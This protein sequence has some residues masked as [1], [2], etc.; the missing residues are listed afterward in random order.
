MELLKVGR[1]VLATAALLG[2]AA[3]LSAQTV[4]YSTAGT[5]SGG[6]GGTTCSST[7]CS[8]DGFTLS[9][10]NAPSTN[11]MAPK[12]IDLGQFMT[13]FSPTGG[14]GPLTAFTGVSFTLVITQ[15]APSNGT[16][17]FTDGIT[18]SLAYNPS[19][20]SLVWSPTATQ[21]SIGFAQYKLVTDNT[22]NVNIQAPTTGTGSNPNPTS[23][24]ANVSVTPEPATL[25][26]LAPGLLGIGAVANVRRRKAA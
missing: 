23:V 26:L 3:T 13:A 22:G 11:Y 19:T 2:S 8:V 5:F 20:S 12:L 18:G 15:T 24:K 6:T 25:L 21:L 14:T 16:G 10:T 1:A 4:T 7:Q 17:S 9:F